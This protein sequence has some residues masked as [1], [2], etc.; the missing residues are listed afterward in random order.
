LEPA[1]A[2]AAYVANRMREQGILLGTDGP[3]HNVIKIRPPMPFD[4]GDADL[5]I[6]TLDRVLGEAC[7]A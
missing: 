5:L 4:M 7:P 3:A 1:G 6:E 2:A